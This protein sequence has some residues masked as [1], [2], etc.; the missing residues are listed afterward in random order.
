MTHTHFIGIGGAGLSAIARVLLE[1]G[2]KVSGSDQEHT[3]MTES[4][5]GAGARVFIGHAKEN[6]VGADLVIR[7]SAVRDDNVEVM[8]ALETGIPVVRREGFLDQLLKDQE[9]VAVA[10]S[11]GKT[12]TTSMI[13]WMLTA[14]GQ[15][16][17]FIAG[18]TIEN[19]GVNARAGE[20]P[21]FVIEADEYDYMFLGLSPSIAIVTNVEHDHPDFFPT[22]EDFA[23]AFR[24][25]VQRLKPDGR[26]AVCLDD[27]G[28]AALL[29]E[30]SL[31]G[32]QT[33]TYGIST[34]A[35]YQARN[36]YSRVGSGFSF[37]VYKQD[38]L[39]TQ[40]ALQIPGKHN[41]LNALAA[42]VLADVLG[43]S[44]EEAAQ[45]LGEF[46]GA[47]RRF[48]V[49]GEIEGIT[50]I[51]DY[52]HHPTEI[53]ATLEAAQDRYPGRYLWALWQPH[54]YSRT[55][56]LLSQYVTAFD[57]A[58]GVIMTPVYE[59]RETRPPDFSHRR[60]AEA[61]DHP[62]VHFANGLTEAEDFLL[63][64]VKGGDVVL[65]LSAGDA[66]EVSVR[67]LSE[68]SE[69]ESQYA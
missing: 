28:A 57:A 45:A 16:P 1:R 12:T 31:E 52:A 37:D 46:R 69:M 54:T 2:E 3:L 59:A 14:L 36:L 17:G 23:Q 55:T 27:P 58:D 19:L 49:V 68:L 11:H 32:K 44:M 25:F 42:L 41:V 30:K 6:V 51:D 22:A 56:K 26:L 4:L 34:D 43:L 9:V 65:I 62:D 64:Q 47:A 63:S 29:K 20:S 39:L 8:A 50:V 33:L 13:A 40:V 35:E 61:I 18:G 38:S 66:V 53:R 7:S 5:E 60:V 48:D 24:D 10:G 21:V 15:K 67:L